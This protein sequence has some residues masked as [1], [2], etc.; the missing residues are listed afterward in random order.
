MTGNLSG[1]DPTPK[2]IHKAEVSRRILADRHFLVDPSSKPIYS[3][4]ER[5]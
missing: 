1:L 2:R 5:F 4:E 3:A